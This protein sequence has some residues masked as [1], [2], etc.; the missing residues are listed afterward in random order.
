M[1][2]FRITSLSV[3]LSVGLTVGSGRNSLAQHN[4][5]QSFTGI[6]GKSL[7]SGSGYL[8]SSPA[9]SISAKKYKTTGDVELNDI[10]NQEG[11]VASAGR[12]NGISFFVKDEIL[13]FVTNINVNITSLVSDKFFPA[14]KEYEG[15]Y[16]CC[17]TDGRQCW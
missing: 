17:L 10:N 15:N 11:L 8:Y 4:T 9:S 5:G 2:V 12:F 16:K 13:Q 14:E 6:T 1:R 7:C 3:I